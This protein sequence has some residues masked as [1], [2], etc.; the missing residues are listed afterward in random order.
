MKRSTGYATEKR[1]KILEYL[2]KHNDEDISVRDIEV[3]LNDQGMTANVSTIY[4]YLEKLEED[5]KILKR[6]SEHG[7]KSTFQYVNPDA[8]CHNHLHMKC[9]ECGKIYHMDCY[10]MK[11]FQ[12]HI[13]EHHHFALECKTSILYGVCEN[14]RNI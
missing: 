10:F 3:H 6:V 14:C 11:E 4:R 2:I 5:G 9:S 8:E 1:N 12:Q 7:G 13:F